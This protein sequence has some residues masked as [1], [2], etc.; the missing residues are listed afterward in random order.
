MVFPKLQP[1]PVSIEMV[2]ET[3]EDDE[4]TI[5][6]NTEGSELPED[7]STPRPSHIGMHTGTQDSQVNETDAEDVEHQATEDIGRE[8]SNIA[9]HFRE[10]QTLQWPL[11][12]NVDMED[13]D[14][15]VD[16]VEEVA[17]QE[18]H[19]A[20]PT[21]CDHDSTE[22]MEVDTAL[23]QPAAIQDSSVV[24][25]DEASFK[26]ADSVLVTRQETSLSSTVIMDESTTEALTPEARLQPETLMWE[27]IREDVT[28]PFD[29]YG[30]LSMSRVL[31]Q[32]EP[33]ERLSIAA[34]WAVHAHDNDTAIPDTH[35]QDGDDFSAQA[36]LPADVSQELSMIQSCDSSRPSMD[37]AI[38]LSD[39]INIESD[40]SSPQ[41]PALPMEVQAEAVVERDSLYTQEVA[42]K[43]PAPSW[44][45]PVTPAKDM[46]VIDVVQ[47]D[48]HNAVAMTPRYAMPTIA[49][50]RKSVPTLPHLTPFGNG[51]RPKT[52]DGASIPTATTPFAEFSRPVRPATATPLKSKQRRPLVTR[53]AMKPRGTYSPS[54]TPVAKTPGTSVPIRTGRIPT[55]TPFSRTLFARTPG[56]SV[57]ETNEP[58]SK[59]RYLGL[60]PRETYEAPDSAGKA[61]PLVAAPSHGGL[62]CAERFPGLPS[63]T[64]YEE[65]VA[66]P[67]TTAARSTTPDKPHASTPALDT[68]SDEVSTPNAV[69]SAL[70]PARAD[71]PTTP[72]PATQERYPGLPVRRTYEE[73]AKTTAPASRFR[74][75][76]QSPAK[77][78]ATVKKPS[79]LRKIALR[80]STPVASRTPDMAQSKAPAMTPGQEP[81]TP[82]PAAPLRGVVALVEV[83]TSD[84]GCATPAFTILLQRLGAKTTKTFSERVTHVVFKEGSPLT[85]QRLRLHNKQVAE[86]DIGTHIHCVNSRW[87]NDCDAEGRRVDEEDEAYAVD[88]EDVPRAGKRRRKSMEPMSLLNNGGN[89]VRDR[90]TSLGRSSLGRTPLRFE[91]P[92]EVKLQ[93]TPEGDVMEKENS[94]DDASSSPATPAYLSAPDSLVQQTAPLNRMKRMNLDEKEQRKNRRLTYFPG[95][96]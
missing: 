7:E 9:R 51:A 86:T 16:G 68:S 34:E 8:S 47:M 50:R 30:D 20:E 27:N 22:A 52:S 88:V 43:D 72:Q 83:F 62:V 33:T 85:L 2:G 74:T 87:V 89:I 4:E 13:S 90:K 54:K 55:R 5:A 73:H 79:S 80:A 95:R 29:F 15:Q 44:Q 65:L 24:Q 66:T 49:S 91:S 37:A 75:P 57:P 45:Q 28:I 94:G 14:L 70:S 60:P 59:E 82:H 12:L 42:A 78:P 38:N 25:P 92:S 36:G 40:P 39:F 17:S 76:S 81:L 10:E 48:H 53:S 77:R 63:R 46:S 11:N 56:T 35:A 23:V 64:T 3:V 32:G 69:S 1:L 58:E 18:E 96:A 41:L 84:G 19:P 71:D 61:S 93:S 67:I 26:S 6:D 21:D 31:P